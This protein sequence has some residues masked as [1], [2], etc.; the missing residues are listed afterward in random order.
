MA[1]MPRFMTAP[2]K[3]RLIVEL[4]RRGCRLKKINWE[5]GMTSAGVSAAFN[6]SR[7]A[8]PRETL[9][10]LDRSH[11]PQSVPR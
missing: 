9:A 3:D 5:V 10:L 11:P 2:E 6:R 1:P 4:R 8:D 7:R